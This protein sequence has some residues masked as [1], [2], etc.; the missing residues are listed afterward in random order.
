MSPTSPTRG[1]LP[2]YV[3][4]FRLCDG[5]ARLQGQLVAAQLPRLS[6]LAAE[7]LAGADVSLHFSRDDQG[8]NRISGV[9]DMIV[10]ATCARCLEWVEVEV[11]APIDLLVVAAGTPLPESTEDLDVVEVV[12]ERLALAGM[13]EDEVLLV[14]PQFPAHVSC[15]VITYASAEEQVTIQPKEKVNP[16]DVLAKLKNKD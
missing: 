12:E 10:R 2:L 3:E 15:K 16:F 4:P 6:E 13:I 8:R 7:P 1:S 9:V 11:H 14:F 5:S